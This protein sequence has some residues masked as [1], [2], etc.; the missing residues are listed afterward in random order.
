MK[1]QQRP[2][3]SSEQEEMLIDCVQELEALYDF[4]HKRYSDNQYKNLMWKEIGEKLQQDAEQCKPRWE[5]IWSQY[6]KIKNSSTG[7][8]ADK[9]PK[10]NN[11]D[12]LE[13]LRPHMKDKQRLTSI[14]SETLS[15]IT[16]DEDESNPENPNDP[17]VPESSSV[18]YA[19]DTPKKGNY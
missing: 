5:S 3:F 7:Q 9:K 10:W 11:E 15:V 2:A 1:R 12:H 18:C 6:R 17:D 16:D 4:S 13:F 19:E 8:A 14:A